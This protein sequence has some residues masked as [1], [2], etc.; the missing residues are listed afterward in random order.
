MFPGEHFKEVKSQKCG[1]S[2][3]MMRLSLKLLV[4]H[5]CIHVRVLLSLLL[6]VF[7]CAYAT[8][9]TLVQ[10]ALP[11]AKDT[12]PELDHQLINDI[13]SLSS[14]GGILESSCALVAIPPCDAD[15]RSILAELS[16]I[17]KD[18]PNV[19]IGLLRVNFQNF[20]ADGPPSVKDG[21]SRSSGEIENTS[22]IDEVTWKS[23]YLKQINDMKA[24][25]DPPKLAFYQKD[26]RDRTCLLMPPKAKHQAEPYNGRLIVE[27]LVQFLNERCGAFRTVE[28]ALTPAGMF[29]NHIMKHLYTPREMI[30]D[31]KRIKMPQTA[32]FFQEF[33]FRSRPVVIED[34]V[35][36]WPAM[37][38]WSAAYLRGLYGEKEIHIKLTEDGNFE[39]VESAKDWTN[40]RED[41]IPEQVKAQ[42][43]FPDLVVVRPAT[44]EMKFS[45]FLDFIATRNDSTY[46]AYLE[47]S[48]I[49]YYMPQ[50]EGDILELPFLKTHLQRRHLNM[51]LSD[52]NTLGKLHFDP[53]DNFLCQVNS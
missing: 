6:Q 25:M 21:I 33:L 35:N 24:S 38:K 4:W 8:D 41:W 28:G 20:S 31:C 7:S 29:H 5:S 23:S 49:P 44:T 30:E 26:P 12:V 17:F 45:N 3:S 34:A 1:M 52:G 42:L 47:Y 10:E 51:W 32:N 53:Y 14:L 18:D 46:S 43:P 2:N 48:S 50:L 11:A 40:Y 39:G 22:L 16:A 19:F 13:E 27:T 15:L 36:D 9:P 37:T